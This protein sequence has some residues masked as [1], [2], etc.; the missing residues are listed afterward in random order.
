MECC[1]QRGEAE[2]IGTLHLSP[3]ENIVSVCMLKRISIRLIIVK[4]NKVY[5]YDNRMSP[6]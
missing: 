6:R 1:N 3:N 2:L 5:R 4:L